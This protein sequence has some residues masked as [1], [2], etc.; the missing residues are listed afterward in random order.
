MDRYKDGDVWIVEKNHSLI[1]Y[2]VFVAREKGD[3]ST[4]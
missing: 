3:A 4:G 2:V 1:C